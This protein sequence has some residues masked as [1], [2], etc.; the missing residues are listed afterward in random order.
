[1]ARTTGPAVRRLETEPVSERPA[2]GSPST[3][4]ARLLPQG[5]ATFPNAPGSRSARRPFGKRWRLRGVPCGP[6]RV[7]EP[8]PPTG[9]TATSIAPPADRWQVLQTREEFSVAGHPDHSRQ[10][11]DEVAARRIRSVRHRSGLVDGGGKLD[12]DSLGLADSAS[13]STASTSRLLESP[14]TTNPV[15]V[16]TGGQDGR[17]AHP[18]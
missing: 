4:A 7:E 16:L 10:P 14:T 17:T 3:R 13:S 5:R 2:P 6:S 1:M 12:S 8:Q 9:T 15:G 11:S 18:T